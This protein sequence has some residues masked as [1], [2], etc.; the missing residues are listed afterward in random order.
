[1]APG[2][3]GRAESGLRRT[4]GINVERAR[5]EQRKR[6]LGSA[7]PSILCRPTGSNTGGAYER[8]GD[9]RVSSVRHAQVGEREKLTKTALDDLDDE[10]NVG[11]GEVLEGG[12]VLRRYESVS[13]GWRRTPGRTYR[14]G[15]IG[16][17]DALYRSIEVVERLGLDDLRADLG[18]HTERREPPLHSYQSAASSVSSRMCQLLQ[19]DHKRTGSSS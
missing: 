13:C 12:G 5:S 15:E 10:G 1:M 4:S 14:S 16:T 8:S 9:E 7:I 18:S 3:D 6:A 2:G 17:S 11:E 19:R